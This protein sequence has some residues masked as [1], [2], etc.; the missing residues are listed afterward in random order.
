MQQTVVYPGSFDPVTNGHLD[1]IKRASSVFDQVIVAVFRNPSKEPLFTM[2]ER[3]DLLY[4]VTKDMK[5]VSIDS[6]TGLTVDYVKSKDAIAIIRGLRAVS[7]F[8]GEFQMASLN[9]ELDGNV[10]TIFFMTDTKFAYLSSSVVKEVAQ[11]GGKIE[12][13]V[14]SNVKKALEEKFSGLID[15]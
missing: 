5:N 4:D 15:N 9:K 12:D 8:E 14:P 2:N 10:E 13:L 3:A 7:D 1:I 6:F 11:F